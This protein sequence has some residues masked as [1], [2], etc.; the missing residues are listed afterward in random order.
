MKK[1]ITSLFLALVSFASFAQSTF[2]RT[3]VTSGTNTYTTSITSYT[4]Y[5]N[6]ELAIR[7][8]NSNSTAS[9]LS[10]NGMSAIALRVWD[11][12]S[13]EVM[14]GGE[15]N[16][17]TVYRLSYFSGGPYFQVH[18]DSDGSSG[19]STD[20]TFETQSGTSYTVD[21]SDNGKII[22]FTNASGCTVELPSTVTAGKSF[23]AVRVEGA[24][25]LQFTDDGAGSVLFTIGNDYTVQFENAWVS[26]VKSNS[27][28]W[29]GTGA[30]GAGSGGGAVD[31]VFGR[32]G[33]VTAQ[34]GDYT[35]S[36]ITNTPS[37][38]IS[39]V[40]TQ[41]AVNELD[42]E[43]QP[44]DSDLTAIAA[45][46]PSNDDFLQRKS[47]AWTNRTVAQVKTDLNLSGT[48]TG[49]QTITL[50]G[51]VTGSGT[52]S[53]ATTLATVNSNVGTFGSATQSNTVTV[54]GKGLIT[55]ISTQ[56]VT[57]AV[58]SIT[59]LASGI[60]TF[61]ATSSSANLAAA[62]TDEVGTGP[63][64]F[65]IDAVNTQ[66]AS[67]TLVLSDAHKEIFMDVATSNNL[68]L[69]THASVGYPL[70]TKIN[71]TRIGSGVTTVLAPSGGTIYSSA[72]VNTDPGRYNVMQAI[73]IANN[74]WILRNGVGN[75]LV[76][77]TT[78]DF[79]SISANTSSTSVS[80]GSS[81]VV[82]T[83]AAVGDPVALGVSVLTTG[84]IYQAQVTS[85]NT[86]QVTAYNV[87]AG[88]VDPASAT[89]SVRVL[90]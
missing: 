43:K 9:T 1:S 69:P 50:T 39:A 13:W 31:D 78:A 28:D 73:K 3:G 70:Y 21:D 10:V 44:L 63:A 37:G 89:F 42:T 87:T 84:I 20:Y 2:L 59:G 26:W 68:Q 51:D 61:L 58:G 86:V 83:D 4:G 46:T 25:E 19:G 67:Y 38:N 72:G 36:Q 16:T 30:F 18:R 64:V 34:S 80:S 40:T 71:I 7:F 5:S 76:G 6:T 12:D 11:G 15:L 79:S 41:A 56:T 85:A 14:T 49:D 53:F 65:A 8:T 66:T 17:N 81:T 47:S 75:G 60:A 77:A 90:K 24:G 55:A 88:S 74:D 35:A 23:T 52:G 32:T 45:L 57:P 27:T 29:Y 82:V 48:N 33:S 62:L 54:N 22:F